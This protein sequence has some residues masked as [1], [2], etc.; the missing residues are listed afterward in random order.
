VIA[1]VIANT[2]SIRT[3]FLKRHQE[4]HE[5]SPS[6]LELWP[7][8]M[9]PGLTNAIMKVAAIAQLASAAMEPRFNPSPEIIV[10]V[11]GLPR[12]G[13]NK[14]VR[15]VPS[16]VSVPST[17]HFTLV[18]FHKGIPKGLRTEPST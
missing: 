17:C 5:P 10:F 8:A 7:L 12:F 16:P 6:W 18:V 15:G 11:A 1:L 4:L 13:A 2:I 9:P 14:P 3:S